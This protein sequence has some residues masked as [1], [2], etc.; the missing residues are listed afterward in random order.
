MIKKGIS[1]LFAAFISAYNIYGEWLEIGEISQYNPVTS[2]AHATIHLEHQ[3][4]QNRDSLYLI[5]SKGVSITRV[6]VR[7]SYLANR[8]VYAVLIPEN[9]IMRIYTG[10]KVAY[11]QKNEKVS[12][13]PD[14]RKILTEYPAEI[15]N[16]KDQSTMVY[17]PEGPFILGSSSKN[18]LHYF[19][20]VRSFNHELYRRLGK[21]PPAYVRISGFYI[22]KYE[23]TIR[24]FKKYLR[25][26]GDQIEIPHKA[27]NLDTPVSGI[28]FRNAANYCRW[29]EKRLPTELEWEKAARGSGIDV[30]WNTKEEKILV[31]NPRIYPTGNQF[32]ST[33]CITSEKGL[34]S[35]VSVH[36]LSD[37]SPYGVM[38]TCGNVLEWTSSWLMPY[39]GNP[40]KSIYFGRKY[41][42]LKGGS[43]TLPAEYA[44]SFIRIPGGLPTLD[45]DIQAGFRCVKPLHTQP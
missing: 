21:K 39:K 45:K 27:I 41:K 16:P 4:I 22:D 10:L 31:P 24:Q 32:D 9:R 44:R 2:E 33:N 40:M 5:N 17:I 14:Q 7:K 30:Y 23:I 12:H 35:P 20:N 26:S 13:L 28:P 8:R 25:Y 19:P 42:V 36:D 34:S 1:F 38:G 11:I 37:A 29:A 43:Y 6:S 18:T 3:F 15:Q